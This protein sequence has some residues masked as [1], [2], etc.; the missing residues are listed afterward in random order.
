[1]TAAG[2]LLVGNGFR[3]GDCKWAFP[4]KL[5]IQVFF[6]AHKEKELSF[7]L[8]TASVGSKSAAGNWLGMGWVVLTLMLAGNG[9]VGEAVHKTSI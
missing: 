9:S 4:N 6:K 3:V 7:A 2:R 8:K 1:M 5:N